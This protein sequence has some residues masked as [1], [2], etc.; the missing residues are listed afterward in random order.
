MALQAL[1]GGRRERLPRLAKRSYS[2][3]P[4][5]P[6]SPPTTLSNSFSATSGLRAI[7]RPRLEITAIEAIG[8]SDDDLLH[9]LDRQLHQPQHHRHRIDV[10]G[11]VLLRSGSASSSWRVPIHS[12]IAAIASRPTPVTASAAGHV[13]QSD[14]CQAAATRQRQHAGDRQDD[15]DD[16]RDGDVLG[17]VEE[18][19]EHVCVP[20]AC[21]SY[22]RLDIEART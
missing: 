20:G 21:A 18:S 7:S 8:F 6:P 2:F 5:L 4:S 17:A 12:E 11:E 9:H 15:A 1:A 3:P 10:A 22:L 19:V 14:S 13:I 16:R